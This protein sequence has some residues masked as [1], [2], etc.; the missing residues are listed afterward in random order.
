MVSDYWTTQLVNAR[1]S[2]NLATMV[3]ALGWL[4]SP[5]HGNWGTE[6]GAS[7]SDHTLTLAQHD[8]LSTPLW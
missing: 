3:L 5:P 4:I 2:Y 7:S 8:C 1:V 6:K